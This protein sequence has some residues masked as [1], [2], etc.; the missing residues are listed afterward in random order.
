VT[1]L[2]GSCGKESPDG[3]RFC[4]A[5]GAP[6]AEPAAEREQRKVLTILFCDVVGSTALGE[7]L[8]PEALRRV[9]RRYFDEMTTI[10]ERHGGRVEKF[11]GDAVVAAFGMPHVR[12]DDALRAV[13]AAAE[14]RERLPEVA[15]ELG[16]GLMFRTGINTG[17]V[18]VG[19]GQTLA[20][21]DAINVAARL[22]QAAAPGEILIGADTR[23]LVR[24]AVRVQ[25][26]EPL[27]LKGKAEPVPAWRLLAIDPSAD[28]LARHLDAPLVGRE[29]ELA[30]L[31]GAYDR[32]VLERSCHLFTLLG[33]AGAGKSRL[34]AELLGLVGEEAT[35]VRGRCLHYGEGV[36]F[37]PL[38]EILKQLG[39]PAAEVLERVAQGDAGSP[40]ELFWQVR[41]LLER[42]A[43]ERPLVAVFEDLQWAQPMLLDL[44]DHIAD[45]SRGEP[46]LLLCV[47]RPELLDDR[48]VWGGGKLNATTV[49]LEPLPVEDCE[50]LLDRLAP[51]L[52]A[53]EHAR[54]VRAGGGNP[55][56]LE[57][58]VALVRDGGGETVPPTIRALLD[59]R[60][61]RLAEDERA[62]ME[63]GAIEGEVF[64]HGAVQ[65]LAPEGQRT[66]VDGRLAALVRKEMIRPERATL[67]GE[68]AFRFRHLLIRD[69]A[70][71]ALPKQARADLHERFATWLEEHATMLVELDEIA[72]WHL[73]Q[74]VRY[75]REL[76]LALDPRLA[77]RA[78]DH[79][80]AGGRKATERQDLRAADSL[81][82][83]ALALVDRGDER[84]AMLA[85][86]LARAIVPSGQMERA[87]PLLDEAEADP[88]TRPGARITRSEQL[89]STDPVEAVR[90][91]EEELPAVIEQLEARGD[92]RELTRAHRAVFMAHWMR[93][94]AAPAAVAGARAVEHARLAGDRGQL[95]DA[96]GWTV[97]PVMIGPNGPEAL[98]RWI[99]ET[100]PLDAGPVLEVAV[101]M[102][103][104][105]LALMRGDFDE[106]RRRHTT[107]DALYATIGFDLLR[108]ALGQGW[109]QLELAA[110]RPT[111]AVRL[112]R[113]Y[114]DLGT[115][116]G[117]R[118]YHP[119]TG[120]WLA[121]ALAAVGEHEE[122]K[123]MA[124]AV[125]EESASVDII[126]FAISR[127]VLA[128]VRMAERALE[129]AERH[130]REAVDFAFQ[131]D[132]PITQGEAL[133]ALGE[134]LR[135]RGEEAEAAASF[136]RAL[137]L[138]E[139]KGDQP[140]AAKARALLEAPQPAP[141]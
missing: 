114:Y 95:A 89:M 18:V 60:L 92:H 82:T 57:E 14:I 91:A 138:F 23:R 64:H 65:A 116:L 7:R 80:A 123:R 96:G 77:P 43:E 139:L 61:E 103:R 126:N 49:L 78:A 25:A 20:T 30:Y 55:L 99:A 87:S 36:T 107:M 119:T 129:D 100:E 76:G 17:E 120:A 131:T 133:L 98:E 90:I 33:S 69:A 9:M 32:A 34:T 52:D 39:A 16:V 19:A 46:I 73:E 22:E 2:C 13:R 79:L 102:A 81:L 117:D 83:R 115:R 38:V 24:D 41:R 12:E 104:A 97:G 62:V 110:G 137:A 121:R 108:S 3:F 5:C 27:E 54:I 84:R 111:V 50:A 42:V 11:I 29:R 93:S 47:A 132:F 37:W 128:R 94:R 4:G 135:A 48:Q 56:F 85:L 86:D 136:E 109:A 67:P 88:R 40:E 6:L 101:E 8:D 10:V 125:E 15:G 31:R 118:S 112:A 44:L 58:M 1:L 74:A 66:A 71:D 45:L 28:P 59:A 68:D 53:A 51:D 113:E 141:D 75:R 124:L 70:Y 21:G 105:H 122:A 26:V 140:S 130:A 127:E 35:V 106:A 72:G 63:R 134:V